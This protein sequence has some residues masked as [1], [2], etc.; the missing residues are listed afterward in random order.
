MFAPNGFY[1]TLLQVAFAGAP[2]D[3]ISFLQPLNE[4]FPMVLIF[5]PNVTAHIDLL[6]AGSEIRI[7]TKIICKLY[8]FYKIKI[9]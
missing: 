5:D 2:A 9:I 7:Y 4:F 3:F 6:F 8:Y 1:Y